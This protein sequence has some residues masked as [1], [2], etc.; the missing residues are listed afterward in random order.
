MILCH[1]KINYISIYERIEVMA[2]TWNVEEMEHRLQKLQQIANMR[3]FGVNNIIDVITGNMDEE[4]K[5][6]LIKAA[7]EF[8]SIVHNTDDNPTGLHLNCISS[9]ETAIDV[10]KEISAAEE[11]E[12]LLVGTF[13]SYEEAEKV[14]TGDTYPVEYDPDEW[15]AVLDSHSKN[16]LK[17][18]Y[19]YKGR[20]L[21]F[22]YH[23]AKPPM[24][25][26]YT[27]WKGV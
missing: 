14:M 15:W 8:N 21:A 26:A 19:P 25:K 22:L 7:D 12:D 24:F 10:V 6:L 4:E 9:G 3:R 5:A 17:M 23:V 1:C 20:A 27:E 11:G 16:V 18:L 2:D 13:K